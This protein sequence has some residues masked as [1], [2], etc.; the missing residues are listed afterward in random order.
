MDIFIPHKH[1]WLILRWYVLQE[2][3]AILIGYLRYA[4]ALQEI[5]PFVFLLMTLLSPWKNI[6]EK[7]KGHG[8]DLSEFL[9]RL[10]LNIFSRAVGAVV[11]LCTILF[12]I[13]VQI[14]LLAMFIVYFGLWMSYPF[15]AFAGI[16]YG[17]AS[18]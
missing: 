5:I 13:I 3:Y 4:R 1:L 17:L 9:E 10:T 15:L 6:Y 14:V 16:F 2:P 11:R 18:L 7:K 8:F 12:G